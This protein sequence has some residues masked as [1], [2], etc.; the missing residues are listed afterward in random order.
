LIVPNRRVQPHSPQCF[1]PAYPQEDLL[2]DPHLL[3]TAV[4]LVGDHPVFRGVPGKVR[5]KEK[6]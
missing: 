2:A 6:K 3:V 4:E 1:D 5:I